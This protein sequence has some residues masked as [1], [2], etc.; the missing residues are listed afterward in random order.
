[1]EHDRKISDK[2]YREKNKEAIAE[3]RK[4]YFENNK[5]RYAEYNKKYYELNKESLFEK[6]D[7]ECGSTICRKHKSRHLKSNVHQAYIKGLN[8]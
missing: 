7:C 6:Y 2:K 5:E 1:M 4:V 3:K 8:K